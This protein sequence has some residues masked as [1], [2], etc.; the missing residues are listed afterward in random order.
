MSRFGVAGV[1][2]IEGHP[3]AR[4][5]DRPASWISIV[6]GRYF[7]AMGIPLICGRLFDDGDSGNTSPVFIIDER[8]ARRY[9][10]GQDPIGARITW[11]KGL[12][13]TNESEPLTGEIIGVVGSVRWGGMAVEP[14]ATTYGWFPQVPAPQITIVT[15]TV[16]DPIAMA[17]VIANQVEELDPNQ[18]IAEIRTMPD[19]VSA[20]L[21][22]PRFTVLLLGS[23]AAITS[24]GTGR[25]DERRMPRM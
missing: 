15:R 23:L 12:Q 20:D 1:F 3:Q 14:P 18:P 25:C 8:V 10:P 19:F 7:E 2:D 4:G 5:Q 16:N 11:P 6:G 21:A 13:Q 24:A 22:Q 9:W 17:G